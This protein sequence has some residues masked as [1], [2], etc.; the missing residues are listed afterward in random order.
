[1]GCLA[2]VLTSHS[3]TLC[4]VSLSAL[5]P[6]GGVTVSL[7]LTQKAPLSLPGSVTV[8]AGCGTAQFFVQAGNISKT[9][10]DSL[11]ASLN[12]TSRSASL[13]L[14]ASTAKHH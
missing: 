9:Q 1:L 3:S 12:G 5:A 8:P 7:H 6:S 11:V 14:S 10:T 13:T 4:V 2:T